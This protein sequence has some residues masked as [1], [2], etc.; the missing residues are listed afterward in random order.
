MEKALGNSYNQGLPF[1][2]ADLQI[3]DCR[4]QL[5]F[6]IVTAGRAV[7]K[8]GV[9]QARSRARSVRSILSKILNGGRKLEC[10]IGV[11][12]ALGVGFGVCRCRVC[13]GLH[14]QCTVV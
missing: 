6:W 13:S 1:E 14:V 5:S 2:K 12:I 10:Y 4:L 7:S 9:Q 3:A 11:H 8:I